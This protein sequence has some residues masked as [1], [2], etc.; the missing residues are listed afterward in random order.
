MEK[1]KKR[2]SSILDDLAL[3]AGR[4]M[5]QDGI[6]E[7]GKVGWRRKKERQRA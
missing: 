2:S 3:L 4:E 5:R 7:G 6:G 1:N